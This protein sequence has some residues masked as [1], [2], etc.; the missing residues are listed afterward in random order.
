MTDVKPAKRLR[1][2]PQKLDV[3]YGE[4]SEQISPIGTRYSTAMA[5]IFGD[6]GYLDSLLA[7][8]AAS[9]MALSELYPKKIPRPDAKRIV[10][11]ADTTHVP[12]SEIRATEATETHHE[13]GA[14]IKELAKKAG[15]SG[16]YV[17]YTLTSADAVESGKAMQLKRGIELLLCTV[18]R[19]RDASLT[20]AEEWRD[21][22]CITRTHGQH[23]I[24]SSFGF[25]FAFF[26][27]CLE[28]SATRLEY[29]LGHFVE[30]KL[31]G[32]VG[33][34]DTATDEGMD[35]MAIEHRAMQMLGI[36]PS[37][38]STQMPP[39]ENIAAIISDIAI[40]CGRVESMAN[41]VKLL[42]RTEILELEETPD[43]RTVSSSAMPHK[44][45]HGNPYI[46][47]RCMSIAK[48]VRGYASSALESV[49]SED[50]R[51]LSASLSD[52][53]I[54]PE[55]F[56]LAD[57]A[58]RLMENVINRVDP[59]AENISRNLNA[60]LGTVTS[61]RVMSRL[62]SAGASREGA[63]KIVREDA[64]SAAR[65]GAQY[66]DVLL[67]DRRV[68][69]LL[70]RKEIIGLSDPRTYLGMSKKI[71]DRTVSAYKGK[72]HSGMRERKRRAK[73]QNNFKNV[74]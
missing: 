19:L 13:M 32:A 33:T 11:V 66:S 21:I 69:A 52:R 73:P 71:I 53:V 25:A 56:V 55:S 30:G 3:S 38:I 39:R 41:Y 27:Y 6:I 4:R 37:G 63:R 62:I 18:E 54:I 58:C 44:N 26:G 34:Y 36:R 42:K 59:V 14:V 20:A 40:L 1:K 70:S 12:P 35:G 61:P 22:P 7:T 67:A 60:T 68:T 50:F 16:R 5:E 43:V 48:V 8:E 10:S 57:Y 2:R 72:K 9:T 51:D 64:I 49:S 46:E 28:K 65:T 23:A 17:H 47:E 15:T 45:L 29:D 31:S 74:V 24:P